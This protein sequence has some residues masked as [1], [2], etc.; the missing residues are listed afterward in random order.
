MVKMFM[1]ALVLT[2]SGCATKE[3]RLGGMICPEGISESQM[4]ADLKACRYYDYEAATRASQPKKVPSECIECL[5]Q[6]GYRIIE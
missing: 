4:H 5:E 1:F 2:I 3:V 6:K